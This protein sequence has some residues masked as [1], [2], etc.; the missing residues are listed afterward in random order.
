MQWVTVLIDILAMM[1]IDEEKTTWDELL[2]AFNDYF[3]VRK[4]V[5]ADKE[6]YRAKFNS[7]KQQPGEPVDEFVQDLYKLVEDCEYSTL[8]EELS[9][10][11]IV[12]GVLNEALSDRLQAKPNLT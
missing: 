7:R 9:R 2:T 4:N 6:S 10:D 3:K 5:I 12:V 8:K 11:N 1:S